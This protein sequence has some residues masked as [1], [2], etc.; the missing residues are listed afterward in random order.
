VLRRAFAF[1]CLSIIVACGARTD[2][3]NGGEEDDASVPDATPFDATLPDVSADITP[4]PPPPPPP[5]PDDAQPPPPID[6]GPPPPP[7]CNIT[8][9]HNFKCEQQCPDIGPI[10]RWCCDEQTETCYAFA[11]KQ[12]PQTIFDAGFD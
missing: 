12:C 8:C 11:G 6:G 5:P 9:K 7:D 4:P 10:D 1:A 2:I 3:P